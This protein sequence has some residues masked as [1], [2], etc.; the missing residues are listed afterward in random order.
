MN[1]SS[2]KPAYQYA[3]HSGKQA[4]AYAALLTFVRVPHRELSFGSFRQLMQPSP[5]LTESPFNT[6]SAETTRVVVRLVHHL[7]RRL[8][9]G[10]FAV[11]VVKKN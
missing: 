7:Q 8:P 6:L 11:V 3:K 4:G 5:Q 9:L 2:S 1:Y 10:M